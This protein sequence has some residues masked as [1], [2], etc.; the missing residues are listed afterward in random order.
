MQLIK[1]AD[2][3]QGWQAQ[4]FDTGEMQVRNGT[5]GEVTWLPKESVDTLIDIV[6]QIR[7]EKA[8]RDLRNHFAKE[9]HHE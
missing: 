9:T 4:L 3:T 1:Q 6:A 5:T 7:N 2:L 8:E